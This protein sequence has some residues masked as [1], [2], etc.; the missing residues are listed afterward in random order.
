MGSSPYTSS[1]P[2]CPLRRRRRGQLYESL[3]SYYGNGILSCFVAASLRFSHFRCCSP[4]APPPPLAFE[5]DSEKLPWG[6]CRAPSPSPPLSLS[7][8][9]AELVSIS[10]L[11]D[12]LLCLISERWNKRARIG[13]LLIPPRRVLRRCV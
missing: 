8:S 11:T 7:F 10:T 13:L 12:F 6:L 9:P 5:S 3:S 1:L 4:L 2:S